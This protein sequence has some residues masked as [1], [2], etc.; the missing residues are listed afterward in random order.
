ML[1]SSQFKKIFYYKIQIKSKL[2]LSSATNISITISKNWKFTNM[3][4]IKNES[5]VLLSEPEFDDTHKELLN[6]ISAIQKCLFPFVLLFFFFE[7]ESSHLLDL[8]FFLRSTF[9]VL[10]S[11]FIFKHWDALIITKSNYF[12]P[13][14]YGPLKNSELSEVLVVGT[15]LIWGFILG[16]TFLN[17][18]NYFWFFVFICVVFYTSY[19]VFL[20][21]YVIY[22]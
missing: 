9:F 19:I 8:R 3:R 1:I 11:F 12:F 16:F 6:L 22:E 13:L 20:L 2:P 5:K 7:V 17:Y 21:K 4:H 18:Y 14:F 15:S 10:L